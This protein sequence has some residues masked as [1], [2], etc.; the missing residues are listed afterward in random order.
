MDYEDAILTGGTVSP[1]MS[2]FEPEIEKQ[3]ATTEEEVL[4]EEEK[5]QEKEP[6]SKEERYI[7]IPYGARKQIVHST[8]Y[9][10]AQEQ[11]AKGFKEGILYGSYATALGVGALFMSLVFVKY[12]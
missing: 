7:V 9:G 8:I 1:P 4:V 11:Y 10:I 5:E 3:E 6:E 12:A 2:V